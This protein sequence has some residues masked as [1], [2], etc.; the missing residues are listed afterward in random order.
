MTKK[1]YV[2]TII[3][4]LQK[5]SD[6]MPSHIQTLIHE[7]GMKVENVSS[8]TFFLQTNGVVTKPAPHQVPDSDNPLA[9]LSEAYFDLKKVAEKNRDTRP[10]FLSTV[11]QLEG[12]LGG[13]ESY[14]PE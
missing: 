4:N 7:A 3:E 11:N 5:H 2:Q 10:E 12:L 8:E 14:Y 13:S 6:L 9:L 1:D